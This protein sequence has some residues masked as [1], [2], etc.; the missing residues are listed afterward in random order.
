MLKEK[1]IAEF[2][3]LMVGSRKFAEGERFGFSPTFG[4][5]W[6]MSNEDFF[7]K[8]G[9][10]NYLKLKGSAGLINNDNWYVKLI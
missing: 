10:I 4:L 6:I 3:G 9:N 8:D 1:Y 7:N 2:S 5:G